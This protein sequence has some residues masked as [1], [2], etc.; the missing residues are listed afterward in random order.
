[1][2]TLG[3]DSKTLSAIQDK[4]HVNLHII[5]E[6]IDRAACTEGYP[7]LKLKALELK[8]KV[9]E[10][11]LADLDSRMA[12]EDLLQKKAATPLVD[13]SPRFDKRSNQFY[14]SETEIV[15]LEYSR[16]CIYKA[17][18]RAADNIQAVCDSVQRPLLSAS[19]IEEEKSVIDRANQ[20]VIEKNSAFANKQISR[21]DFIRQRL[22]VLYARLPECSATGPSSIFEHDKFKTEADQRH[23]ASGFLRK[24]RGTKHNCSGFG[25]TN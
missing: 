24:H 11:K 23:G 5:I 6:S 19:V 4:I 16:S 12:I 21:I 25:L 13:H 22:E 1:M 7:V 8:R 10:M 17:L 2:K 15:M 18:Y 14:G 20:I 9:S 3:L